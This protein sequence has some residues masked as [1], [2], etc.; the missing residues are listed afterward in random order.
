MKDFERYTAAG[1][2][3]E[4]VGQSAKRGI[5]GAILGPLVGS[6]AGAATLIVMTSPLL[7]GIGVIPG[8]A[9]GAIAAIASGGMGFFG[10]FAATTAAAAGVMAI[11]VGIAGATG[12]TIAGPFVGLAGG[13]F[14]GATKGA[15]TVGRQNAR[16]NAIEVETARFNNAM[17]ERAAVQNV[18]LAQSMTPQP[19]QPRYH[20][21][22][23]AMQAAEMPSHKISNIEH[24]GMMAAPELA[25]GKA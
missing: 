22:V 15:D 21:P 7:L 10:G 13:L 8:L 5:M 6:I 23:A 1:A 12:G 2:T 4:V 20:Q 25:L 9:G 11:P 18:A 17:Q 24:A 16:A 19:A 14:S 3:G